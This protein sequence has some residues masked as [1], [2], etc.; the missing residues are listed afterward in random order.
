M[1][2]GRL[3]GKSS[4]LH[5]CCSR[6]GTKRKQSSNL[7]HKKGLS[8]PL[9]QGFSEQL[10]FRWVP[11]LP[12]A[13]FFKSTVTTKVTF[14]VSNTKIWLGTWLCSA[15]FKKKLKYQR[16]IKQHWP[17]GCNWYSL[18]VYQKYFKSLITKRNTDKNIRSWLR[19]IIT[20]SLFWGWNDS[21]PLFVKSLYVSMVYK[22]VLLL[23]STQQHCC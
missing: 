7:I 17:H 18:L 13:L 2:K 15:T 11:F 16:Y 12:P 21:Y 10:L 5:T 8:H 1:W 14:Y 6:H 20:S 9:Y 19:L 22:L 3:N 23:V 4:D